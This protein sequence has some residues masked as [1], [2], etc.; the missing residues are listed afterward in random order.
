VRSVHGHWPYTAGNAPSPRHGRQDH[1]GHHLLPLAE[2]GVRQ[3]P[4]LTR[5]SAESASEDPTPPHLSS[6][7]DWPA[8]HFARGAGLRV[9][10]IGESARTAE[11]RS[12]LHH[13]AAA[14]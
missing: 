1:H 7:L 8:R 12:P 2:I 11:L 4:S 9:L 10:P 13:R 6:P 3:F 14:P 5:S